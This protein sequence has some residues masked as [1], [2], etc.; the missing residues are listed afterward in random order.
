MKFAAGASRGAVGKHLPERIEVSF[1]DEY[2]TVIKW[3]FR[4]LAANDDLSE[5][6][7]LVVAPEKEHL[8]GLAFGSPH[9]LLRPGDLV[10]VHFTL[11]SAQ[12]GF[13]VPVE[14]IT[15]V[16]GEHAVFVVE[17]GVARLRKVAVRETFRDLRRIEGDGIASGAAMIVS[18]VHYVS[19]G[20]AVTIVDADRLPR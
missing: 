7:F 16:G 14:A 5:G 11:G 17:D 10:P 8:R 2:F 9:W 15:K 3:N 19:D 20:Q 1:G 18:G 6:D 12:R 13:Y 4:S